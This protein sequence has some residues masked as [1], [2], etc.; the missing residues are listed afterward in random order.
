MG[1]ILMKEKQFRDFI[2]CLKK[3]ADA[4]PIPTRHGYV[5][6]IN[7]T[8]VPIGNLL[9]SNRDKKKEFIDNFKQYIYNAAILTKNKNIIEIIGNCL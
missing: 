3:N 7:G 1:S 8:K 6:I 5:L 9:K 4:Y 2:N